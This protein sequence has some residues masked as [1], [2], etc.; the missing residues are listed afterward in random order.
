M[1]VDIRDLELLDALGEHTTLTAAARHLYVS[2]PALS[3]RL[4]RLEERLG[5]P[6][7]DRRGR[8]LIA[9][10]AGRRMLH[11]ALVTLRELR[12]ARL[13]LHELA[14]GRRRPLRLASQ[15]ATNYQWMANVVPSLRRQLPGTELRIEPLPDDDP[16]A[17]LLGDRLDVA[18]VTK[19]DGDVNH[20]RLERL[21]DD[22][23]RAVV[24]S[25]HP[26]ADR[27]SV[28]AA[29]FAEVHLVLCEGYDQSR[30]P[31]VPLPIPDGARPGRI[32][33]VAIGNDMLIE[34]V[35][36]GEAV[37]VLPSW[38]A[39][40]YLATHDIVSVAVGD[41][42]QR[43]TWYSATRHERSD[44][45]DAVNGSLHAHLAGQPPRVRTSAAA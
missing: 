35:A 23:L 34:L 25:S 8:R 12:A 29:D 40:P 6:L 30:F 2:Q 15:C 31:A 13:D 11:A 43:R 36:T 32:T 4:L 22:E 26:W 3:Q 42:P 10:A 37:T 16:I 41:P 17:A 7:F 45:V 27:A 1:D 28:A 20:V 38:I 39:A 5:I 33:T 18:L 14:D 21:F 24:S 19:L 44:A 9:N